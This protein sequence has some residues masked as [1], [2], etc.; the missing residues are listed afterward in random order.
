MKFFLEIKNKKIAAGLFGIHYKEGYNHWMGWVTNIDWK[1]S[2]YKDTVL[3]LL[4]ESGNRVD[5]YFSTYESPKSGDL[6][7]DFTPIKYKFTPFGSNKPTNKTPSVFRHNRFKETLNLIPE[8]YDY[9][10]ITRFDLKFSPEH[11]LQAEVND[12]AVNVSSR[13]CSGDKCDDV[14]DNFYIISNRYF[15]IFKDFIN[16]IPEHTCYHTINRMDNKPEISFMI[17]GEYYSHTCPMY[18]TL[19]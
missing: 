17:E 6:L 14:C 8:G 5:H 12:D 3:K 2:N 1:T 18:Q 15:N 19:R 16:N 7:L 11:L 10:L 13:W 4:N 9:Y